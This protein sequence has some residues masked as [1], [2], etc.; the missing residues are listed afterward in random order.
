MRE[1]GKI[2]T[3]NS[4]MA[5]LA[6]ATTMA[7][8]RA[9][10]RNDFRENALFVVTGV[11]SRTEFLHPSYF[12]YTFKDDS[13][14]HDIHMTNHLPLASIGDR[15][16]VHGHLGF[17]ESGWRRAYADRMEK[18][19]IA[20]IPAPQPITPDQLGDS[21]LYGR[22][23]M[24]DGILTDI[25]TD[26]ID[27]RYKYLILRSNGRTFL[28]STDPSVKWNLDESLIGSLLTLTGKAETS[29]YGGK[30]KHW[31]PHLSW[32][33]AI[34]VKQ[35][36]P[37]SPFDVPDITTLDFLSPSEISGLNRRK[38][39][40]TV[41]AAF[42]NSNVLLRTADGKIVRGELEK[43][44]LL[45][46]GDGIE[47][48]GFPETD[49]FVLHL[50][51]AKFRRIPASPAEANEPRLVTASTVLSSPTGKHAIQ[52]EYYGQLLRMS[53]KV[54]N[55]PTRNT[56]PGCYLIRS[57]EHLVWI[58]VS[59][60]QGNSPSLLP[61][62]VI[63]ITGYC[64]MNTELWQPTR[65]M[66]RID[67][68]TLVPRSE[69]DIRILSGPPWWTPR[70]F[71]TALISLVT[72]LIGIAIWNRA[73]QKMVRNRSQQLFRAEI[74]KAESDLR[75]DERTRLAADLHD[76]LSQSLSGLACQ[77]AAIRCSLHYSA[78]ATMR[79]LDNAERMLL[80]S[81]TE[82]KRCLWDLRS[83][84]LSM[85]SFQ[86]AIRE[87]LL[88]ILNEAGLRI[89]FNVPRSQTSDSTA[90]AIISI[91]R[92]LVSNS[93]NHGNARRI[94]IAG[95]LQDGILRFSVRDDG[96]GFDPG[97]C[98]GVSNGHFGLQGIRER[99][100]R[101]HGDFTLQSTIGAGTRAEVTINV[102]H[103]ADHPSE[104]K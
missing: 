7:G 78:D 10:I 63:D 16:I 6:V 99:V 32:V 67:G 43:P 97:T 90:H 52:A 37:L 47:L 70:R 17:E 84:I 65:I 58:D 29:P 39:T 50:N 24:M 73:L 98:G 21:L 28:A 85:E 45:H 59:S 60:I 14:C 11:V 55:I 87:T 88:P 74:A 92:E 9:S 8:L 3:M 62:A 93:V 71:L 26:D 54:L 100:K 44:A 104:K 103:D 36:A 41:L 18:I 102:R 1:Y 89:R 4:T 76:S 46:N 96:T 5:I 34:T 42:Q 23:V 51:K 22:T 72:I 2:Q 27:P 35:K 38:A 64:V 80:S 19:G 101:F 91:I 61:D 53:G 48:V 95:D 57:E 75:I 33:S 30:R 56:K 20:T 94:L 81:R 15:M 83:D 25:I 86:D 68:F 69:S 66:P 77:I 82:L 79:T 49:L 13:G 12:S 31:E 40:G